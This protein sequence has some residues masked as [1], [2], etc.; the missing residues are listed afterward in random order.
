[1][2]CGDFLD[3]LRDLREW[4]EGEDQRLCD[5]LSQAADTIARLTDE[6]DEAYERAAQVA[7]QRMDARFEE[8]G[9]REWDTNA[10]VYSGAAGEIYEALDEEDEAI[11]QAIRDLKQ[12]G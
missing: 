2:A 7:E 6:R 8:Y 12:K 11:A 3:E 9:T 4:W 5:A 10:C 1:M